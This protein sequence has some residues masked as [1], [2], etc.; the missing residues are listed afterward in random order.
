MTGSTNFAVATVE[1]SWLVSALPPSV[2]GA[3]ATVTAP[4]VNQFDPS[5]DH[6]PVNVFPRRVRRRTTGATPEI[7]V[8]CTLVAPAVGRYC[9]AMPLPGVTN[10][11]TCAEFA[12]VV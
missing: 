6:A 5:E 4:T 7:C 1:V 2:L 9:M 10:T 12:A 3:S 8:T 11:D